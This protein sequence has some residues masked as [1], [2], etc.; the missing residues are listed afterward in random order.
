[1]WVMMASKRKRR[2]GSI[3]LWLHHGTSSH[4]VKVQG[5]A[6]TKMRDEEDAHVS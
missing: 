5:G 4:S 3:T 1:M 6:S 2:E